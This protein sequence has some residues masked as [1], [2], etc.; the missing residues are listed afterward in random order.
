M[1]GI[2]GSRSLGL[3][4]STT[5]GLPIPSQS[6]NRNPVNAEIMVRF[7]CGNH[8]ETREETG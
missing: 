3:G 2:G 5:V 4:V 8:E 6:F 1:L 7:T